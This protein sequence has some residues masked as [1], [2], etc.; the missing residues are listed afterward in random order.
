M[1]Y[2]GLGSVFASAALVAFGCSTS[3][4]PGD[5]ETHWVVC[6]TTADC[7]GGQTCEHTRCVDPAQAD[8]GTPGTADA[9]PV[10]PDGRATITNP[11]G[12]CVAPDSGTRAGYSYVPP[13]DT[14]LPDCKN[15]LKREY[16]RVFTQSDG[17]AY[18]IPR[19][20][21][22]YELA[23]PCNEPPHP[24]TALVQKYSLCETASDLATEERINHMTPADALMLTHYMNSVLIFEAQESVPNTNPMTFVVRPFP[25]PSD[26]VDACALRPMELSLDLAT[27]CAAERAAIDS[28]LESPTFSTTAGELATLLNGLYGVGGCVLPDQAGRQCTQCGGGGCSKV[29]TVCTRPCTTS[30]DCIGS[31]AGSDCIAG[32]CRAPSTFCPF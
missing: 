28:G 14:W 6:K 16:Y 8:G 3:V 13:G 20:D 4:S 22:A 30:A 2:F 21:G 15:P 18:V 31:S 26:V 19:P 10:A 24:L 17:S 29:E 9:N 1:K 25:I 12:T 5:S 23:L 11:T 27:D 7:H 32:D